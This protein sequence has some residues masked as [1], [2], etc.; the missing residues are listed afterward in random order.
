VLVESWLARA[1]RTRP[2]AVALETAGARMSYAQLD[3]AATSAARRL[4][5]RGARPGD[6][7]ALALPAGAAFV[8]ALHGCLRLGAVA[9][10]IDL[11]LPDGERAARAGGCAAVVDAPLDG[12]EDAGAAPTD[13]K[14][15]V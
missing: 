15:V 12:A 1:A 7:V 5:A 10:P 3:A 9:V 2:D 11:R 4:A 8:E 13:R 6:R 14:S